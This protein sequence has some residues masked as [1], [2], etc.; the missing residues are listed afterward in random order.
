MLATPEGFQ[1]CPYKR[2]DE[3][4]PWFKQHEKVAKSYKM[5]VLQVLPAR[6]DEQERP[7]VREL[8]SDGM[9]RLRSNTG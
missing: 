8:R 5:A 1:Y 3:L 4:T 6:A 7:H 9:F 2:Q